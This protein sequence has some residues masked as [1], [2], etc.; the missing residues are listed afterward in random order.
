MGSAVVRL[1]GWLARLYVKIDGLVNNLLS[2]FG[3]EVERKR[4]RISIG[5]FAGR[6]SVFTGGEGEL[7]VVF[8]RLASP[9]RQVRIAAFFPHV[10]LA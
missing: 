8:D 4:G 1:R 2:N 6:E 3:V 10:P 5:L 7:G 9:D